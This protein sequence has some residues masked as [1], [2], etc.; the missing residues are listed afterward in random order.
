MNCIKCGLE[1]DEK[2]FGEI[3]RASLLALGSQHASVNGC[4][5]ISSNLDAV[6]KSLV[7]KKSK[8]EEAEK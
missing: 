2:Q 8:K 5:G 6:L 1:L 3:G 7:V 4:D